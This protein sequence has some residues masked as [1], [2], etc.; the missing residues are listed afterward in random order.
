MSMDEIIFVLG[1]PDPEMEQIEGLLRDAGVACIHA[2]VDDEKAPGGQRRVRPDEAYSRRAKAHL[3]A[4]APT[5]IASVVLVECNVDVDYMLADVG[6]THR[7]VTVD[8]IDHHNPGDDGYGRAPDV[9]LVASS[10]GQVITFLAGCGARF[11]HWPTTSS[12]PRHVG[13]ERVILG[14]VA[15]VDNGRWMVVVDDPV[16]WAEIPREVILTAAADHC[17]GA[18]YRG[19][20]P[21]VDPDE[22]MR[23]RA[24]SRARFQ[25]R[26]VEEVLSTIAA[27]QDEI[28]RAPVLEFPGEDGPVRAVDMRRDI[29]VQELPEAALRL[30]VAYMSGPLI[31]PDGKRKYTFSG[32]PEKVRAWMAWAPSVGLTG[33]YGDP[34][35]GFA[36][37]YE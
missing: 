8:R 33:L 7:Y 11:Q 34:M 16:R 13:A 19:E 26:S 9:F 23:W 24:E 5:S 28:R 2:M 1:A 18:A 37:G 31:G 30:G 29:P 15:C 14:V 4:I 10:I 3:R 25:R 6:G 12:V 36:G 22:L 20:C 21:G 27:A 17:L 32:E 35:R